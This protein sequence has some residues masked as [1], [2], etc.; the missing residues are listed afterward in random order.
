MEIGKYHQSGLIT[1]VFFERQFPAQRLVVGQGEQIQMCA[2]D[3]HAGNV[4]TSS[5]HLRP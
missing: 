4:S 2:R 1:K 3:S 5:G